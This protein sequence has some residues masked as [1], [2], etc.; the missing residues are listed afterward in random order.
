MPAYVYVL[1]HLGI[2]SDRAK[3]AGCRIIRI[4][5]DCVNLEGTV[6]LNWLG[7]VVVRR[8]GGLPAGACGENAG[9]G[10]IG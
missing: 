1:W 6:P 5:G 4:G 8:E 2:N 3:P 10:S 9:G 7:Q